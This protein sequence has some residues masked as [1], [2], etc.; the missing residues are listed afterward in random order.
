MGTWRPT[1]FFAQR[2]SV[3]KARHTARHAHQINKLQEK[4]RRSV[5]KVDG[6]IEKIAQNLA[7][8]CAS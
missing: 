4:F 6:R 1:S 2:S 8:S 7:T 5:I 3:W